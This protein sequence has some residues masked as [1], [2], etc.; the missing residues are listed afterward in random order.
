MDDTTPVDTTNK[1]SD[2]YI[3]ASVQ[4]LLDGINATVV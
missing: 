4:K 2:E 3:G 1:L